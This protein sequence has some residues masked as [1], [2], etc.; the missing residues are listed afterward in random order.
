MCVWRRGVIVL[1]KPFLY[2]QSLETHLEFQPRAVQSSSGEGGRKTWV[3]MREC[4]RQ[5]R[6][7]VLSTQ[8]GCPFTFSPD[9]SFPGASTSGWG[10]WGGRCGLMVI[11]LGGG[12]TAGCPQNTLVL[13]F[14]P[15]APM[16]MREH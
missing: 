3:W 6:Q 10:S 8:P 1:V 11:K 16:V 4:K 5:I 14:R 13:S 15:Q 12:R 7:Q 2:P 9:L